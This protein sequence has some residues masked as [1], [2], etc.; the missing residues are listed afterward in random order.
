MYV[1]DR[2]LR[3]YDN[4]SL[5]EKIWYNGGKGFVIGSR[6]TEN[7][8]A[9]KNSSL[10]SSGQREMENREER[11]RHCQAFDGVDADRQQVMQP[12]S[13]KETRHERR[14]LTWSGGEHQSFKYDSNAL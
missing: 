2:V 7:C 13:E 3:F 4:T 5:L 12:L 14:D 9:A 8:S 6:M 11:L 1:E 10:V